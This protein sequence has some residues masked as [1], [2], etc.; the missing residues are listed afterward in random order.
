MNGSIT[1]RGADIQSENF[2]AEN[3]AVI[4]K[5]WPGLARR[6]LNIKPGERVITELAR[7]NQMTAVITT[8]N[9]RLYVHSTYNPSSEA[10]RLAESIPYDQ[11]FFLVLYGFGLGYYAENIL[12]R[13]N[14]KCRLIV[15]EPD[16]E[17]FA[18]ALRSRNLR[19]VL[20]NDAIFITGG[21]AS[22]V[23]Q[24]L[25]ALIH[26]TYLFTVSN[27]HFITL[28][29]CRRLYYDFVRQTRERL[30]RQIHSMLFEIGNDV[31]DTL[32]GLRQSFANLKTILRTPSLSSLK[33]AY[34]G[35]PAI[36]VSAGPSL[37]KNVDLLDRAKGKALILATDAV[38]K[39][40]LK[41]G[42][43]PDAVLSVER[44][45]ETYN[46]FY[47]NVDIPREI[48]LV[49]LSVLVPE[50][51]NYYPGKKLVVFRQGEA[52]SEWIAGVMGAE[53]LLKVGG[54][55]AHLAF[56]L[57]RHLGA[58]PIIFVGQ[59][60]AYSP[61]GETHGVGEYY[62]ERVD[63][64]K[65]EE[66]VPDY[67]G[68]LIPSTRIWKNFL[69][70]FETEIAETNAICIDATEGGAYIQGT[71]IMTLNE[72]LEK[73]AHRAI[74]PF[75]E[76]IP[77]DNCRTLERYELFKVLMKEQINK[78]N[79]LSSKAIQAIKNSRRMQQMLALGG[80]RSP[81]EIRRFQRMLELNDKH[82]VEIFQEPFLRAFIQTLVTITHFKINKLGI[83]DN[84]NKLEQ[85]LR[86]QESTFQQI[87]GI[88]KVI[89]NELEL[90]YQQA[91]DV[92]NS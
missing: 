81:K 61:E 64:N 92:L 43:L 76:V 67:N 41:K 36:I 40:L 79:A 22:Q 18:V 23:E 5:R 37:K 62:G 72:A 53:S 65:A 45:F 20:S 1:S 25:A 29:Y 66:Y 9:E 85:S 30:F 56:S 83:I 74:K 6:I 51:F 13:L 21:D 63:V 90:L 46:Y 35:K 50:I 26:T 78:N 80:A 4:A 47:R 57:A 49:G 89:N 39:L 11:T 88:I 58:N 59:D 2:F 15:I 54:S 69:T 3:M 28:P 84:P 24:D 14:K 68:K 17:L 8:G 87:D 10:Q 16:L 77:E 32:T 55:V 73:Y 38:L 44:G 60:L 91:I 48:V 42:I 7:N 52:L 33:G 19:Q 71:L 31:A 75:Y 27:M 70:W 86:I 12:P 82:L 34:D